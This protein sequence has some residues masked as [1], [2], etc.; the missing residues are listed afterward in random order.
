MLKMFFEFGCHTPDSIFTMVC[1]DWDPNKAVVR[2][3]EEVFIA[4]PLIEWPA[5]GEKQKL[6]DNEDSRFTFTY[7]FVYGSN[8]NADGATEDDDVMI[9]P[10]PA[11]LA[12]EEEEGRVRHRPRPRDRHSGRGDHPGVL[13]RRGLL[14]RAA[15]EGRPRR[16]SRRHGDGRGHGHRV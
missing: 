15:P 11:P 7:K 13:L 1:Y 4:D 9:V 14:H 8:L 3:G 2:A 6:I 16:G 5:S 12:I 10:A